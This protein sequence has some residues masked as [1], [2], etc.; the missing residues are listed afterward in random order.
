MKRLLLFL[1]A[2]ALFAAIDGAVV[3]GTT[4][5]PQAGATVML[6]KLGQNGMSPAGS[7]KTD[8]AGK[9]SFDTAASDMH[10]IQV[11]YKGVTYN[12][13]LQPGAPASGLQISVFETSTAPIAPDQHMVLLE[14]DG[15]DLVA[16][17]TVIFKNDGK[18]TWIDPARGTFHFYVPAAAGPNVRV[19][20]TAPGGMPIERPAQ[21]TSEKGV[22]MVDYPVK[23]GGETRFDV[24]YK[25]PVKEPITYQGRILHTGGELRLVVPSGMKAEGKAIKLLGTEP[26]TQASI[27]DITDRNF[28]VTLAGTGQ[29]RQLQPTER[30]EEEGPR[31]ESIAPPGYERNKYLLLG[32]MLGVL[33]LG[34]A[35]Q[36]LKGGE[37]KA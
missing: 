22:W 20:A 31:I 1:C 6:T 24:S 16:N 3:N 23:A 32:L 10:L 21:K 8:S 4:G 33:A 28:E 36:F 14:T 37:R 27:Y 17:E 35:A 18:T 29:I 26:S 11:N 13:S 19:R 5:Q 9:F 25:L 30:T 34:F 12:L 2:P 15:Q 7:V